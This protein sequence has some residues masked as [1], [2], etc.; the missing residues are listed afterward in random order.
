MSELKMKHY[1]LG[2]CFDVPGDSVLLIEKN[3]PDWQKGN[4]NGVGGHIEDGE[5]PIDAMRREFKEETGLTLRMWDHTVVYTCP[6]GTVYV[7]RGFHSSIEDAKTMTDEK[8]GMWPVDA[9]PPRHMSNLD[10]LIPL[11]DADI[12]WPLSMHLTATSRGAVPKRI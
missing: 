9:L 3:R 4:W 10:W 5:T 8:V 11:Q 12:A 7:F 1:V 2:F 6:G